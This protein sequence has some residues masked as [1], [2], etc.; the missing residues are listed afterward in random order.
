MLGKVEKIKATVLRNNMCFIVKPTQKQATG[1]LE[2]GVYDSVV[3]G[4][5]WKCITTSSKVWRYCTFARCGNKVAKRDWQLQ[6]SSNCDSLTRK[7][8]FIPPN[9]TIMLLSVDKYY[10][11]CQTCLMSSRFPLSLYI[12]K[13][14]K[15]MFCISRF[16]RRDKEEEGKEKIRVRE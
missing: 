11:F 16:G 7:S 5:K 1:T 2:P 15:L 9:S 4:I 3:L 12:A 8:P 6:N 10:H 14:S 13:S